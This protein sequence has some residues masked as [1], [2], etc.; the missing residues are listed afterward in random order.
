MSSTGEIAVGRSVGGWIAWH[1]GASVLL[2]ALVSA[3]LGGSFWDFGALQLPV[4]QGLLAG[5]AVAAVSLIMDR[6]DGGLV[7]RTLAGL[8]SAMVGFGL[9]ALWLVLTD[10]PASRLLLVA[11]IGLGGGVL[12]LRQW[13][14][15]RHR[16]LG[17]A[18]LLPVSLAIATATAGVR[19]SAPAATG[20]QV[21][22][23]ET[24]Y[25]SV[26]TTFHEGL[27]PRGSSNIAVGIADAGAY[28]ILAGPEGA[29][30]DLTWDSSG[31]PVVR[32]LDLRVPFDRSGFVQAT[33]LGSFIEYFR[34]LDIHLTE[35]GTLLASYH[36]W[37]DSERCFVVRVSAVSDFARVRDG[38]SDGSW[39]TV[40]DTSPCLEPYYPHP[41]WPF[42]GMEGGGRMQT[43]G[44]SLLLT[45]GDH[46]FNGIDF[47]EDLVQDSAADYGKTLLVRRREGEREVFSVGHRNAQG[48]LVDGDHVWLT[49]H[50]PEGGDE[51]NLIVPGGNYGW[52]LVTYGTDYGQPIWPLGEDP[53]RH[54]GYLRP[55]VSW[56]PSVGISNLIRL[57]GASFERW[58]G[59]LLLSSLA[60]E[61][62]L[63][64][65]LTEDLQVAYVEPI[66]I[67]RRVR[68]LT[69]LPDGRIL[70][71]LDD[72]S[73]GV[74]E[75][76][77]SPF[78]AC[79]GC[80]PANMADRSAI[81]PPLAGVIGRDI[82]S[83]DGYVYSRGL[84]DLDGSWTEEAL[85]RYLADPQAFA[86]GTS[87]LIEGIPN[88][89]ARA[90]LID[91]LRA[92]D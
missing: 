61:R 24:A 22:L 67:G 87:M 82:A 52:P 48:L 2:L 19:L 84:S 64:V 79:A 57:R 73:L 31:A 74:L 55:L 13:I 46:G 54:A 77:D 88:A 47:P 76:A 25:H 9:F 72:Y 3:R 92:L 59:D 90:A 75:V 39:E 8:R 16:P 63:R 58:Q 89:A 86:P 78:S 42:R 70:L 35:D 15:E 41:G 21:S 50:G 28:Q 23:G 6:G 44:D 81:G 40:Y 49:E 29:L 5:Y 43:V 85:D 83:V 69:E 51:L 80:H 10:A 4:A 27:V 68:D 56:V 62:L 34:V 36:H 20:I 53:N 12:L 65:R 18:L 91:Y 32:T 71:L 66:T 26:R 11:G 7:A 60:G 38:T 37:R 14:P 17:G 30:F 33:S 1:T 45:V